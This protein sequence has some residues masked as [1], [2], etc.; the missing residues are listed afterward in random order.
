MVLT[1]LDSIIGFR[2]F[3]ATPFKIHTLL[4]EDFGKVYYRG[5]V[6][7]QIHLPSVRF[8]DATYYRESKKIFNLEVP[9]EVIYLQ[10]TFPLCYM[11][12]KSST[13]GVLNSNGVAQ[14]SVN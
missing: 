11:F 14:C 6:N 1:K 3:W 8:V 10:F 5:S 12:L 2:T 7:F 9:N 4:V 13:G